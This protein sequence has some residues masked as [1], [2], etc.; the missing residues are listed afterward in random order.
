[1]E[2][3]GFDEADLALMCSS[4]NSEEKH[5][6]RAKAMLAKSP[7]KESELQCGGHL[8]IPCD[9]NLAQERN[10]TITGLQR[11]FWQ[12]YRRRGWCC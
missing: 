3:F 12:S 5:V 10:F 8:A 9:E 2:Q 6:E 11:L 7:A 4:Y 1:M